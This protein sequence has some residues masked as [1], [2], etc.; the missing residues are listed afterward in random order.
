M[1]FDAVIIPGGGVCDDGTLPPWAAARFHLALELEPDGPF[2]ALSGGTPHRLTPLDPHG[3]PVFEAL[4]GARYL[5]ERGVPDHRI[6][7]E[8]SSYDTIGNAFFARV[9]HT[10]VR[11]WRRLLIVNSAFH[12]ARTEAIFRWM[13]SLAPERG[14]ELTFATSADCGMPEDI[15]SARIARE[16]VS[17]AQFRETAKQLQNLA[18][19]HEWLYADHGAY[20]AESVLAAPVHD[21]KLSRLY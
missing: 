14:Y 11:N 8:I 20:Q 17:L 10:D 6:Y 9:Q 2:I 16:Q 19:V 5:L 7:T 4:A 15:R 13:F 1:S 18:Q 12:M 21:P 3:R